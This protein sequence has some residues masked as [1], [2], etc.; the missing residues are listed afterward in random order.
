MF[1]FSQSTGRFW[2]G[3]FSAS[4]AIEYWGYAGNSTRALTDPFDPKVNKFFPGEG[5]NNPA[6]QTIKMLG[7]LPRGCY[8]IGKPYTH[9]TLGI[10]TFNLI[11]DQGVQMYDRGDFRIHGDHKVPPFG[12]ASEGCIVVSH[13]ARVRLAAVQIDP[14]DGDSRLEVLE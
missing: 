4:E 1:T 8:T 11:P 9:P 5:R 13:A 7:P 6:M 2:R 12:L 14:A 3:A 10:L